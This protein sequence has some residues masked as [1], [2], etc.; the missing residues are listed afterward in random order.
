MKNKNGLLE[1]YFSNDGSLMYKCFFNNGKQ[2]GYEETHYHWKKEF[3]HKTY[4][5]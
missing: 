4:Y 5:I 1:V 2:V 3:S